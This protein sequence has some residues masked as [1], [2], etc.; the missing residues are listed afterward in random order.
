MPGSPIRD[1]SPNQPPL[2]LEYLQVF[3]DLRANS[4]TGETSA[5]RLYRIADDVLAL[6]G[7]LRSK[8]SLPSVHYPRQ[9]ATRKSPAG[10]GIA[11]K[12]P[13]LPKAAGAIK[14]KVNLI[15]TSSCEVRTENFLPLLQ[16]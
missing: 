1:A 4:A 12:H 9:G 8:R 7:R 3:T 6:Q 16:P 2:G 14:T 5:I 10:G 15:L 11:V 13:V